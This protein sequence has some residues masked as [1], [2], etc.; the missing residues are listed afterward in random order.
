MKDIQSS[1]GG[2]T[3]P[4]E[5]ETT[6]IV[7]GVVVRNKGAY[8][9]RIGILTDDAS[10]TAGPKAHGSDYAYA[11]LA[12]ETLPEGYTAGVEVE[13]SP[14]RQYHKV[15][16]ILGFFPTRYIHI[17]G[18]LGRTD[19]V[20]YGEMS[21]QV[22]DF[23]ADAEKLG[24]VASTSE[25][26]LL[27][28]GLGNYFFSFSIH[29]KGKA[30]HFGFDGLKHPAR[31]TGDLN[32]Q[33]RKVLPG[34]AGYFEL[35]E[36]APAQT[37]NGEIRAQMRLN[38]YLSVKPEVGNLEI[39]AYRIPDYATTQ[40]LGDALLPSTPM[41]INNELVDHITVNAAGVTIAPS[42]GEYVTTYRDEVLPTATTLVENAIN[43]Y[44]PGNFQD[45]GDHF[46]WEPTIAQSEFRTYPA[47]PRF[48]VAVLEL[49]HPNEL[50]LVGLKLT[51]AKYKLLS[52][53]RKADFLPIRGVFTSD[54]FTRA[55]PSTIFTD[56]LN[57]KE[58]VLN[59]DSLTSELAYE[60]G[61]MNGQTATVLSKTGGV[62]R[63]HYVA[64]IA[65]P[66]D[67]NDVPYFRA[68]E[69]VTLSIKLDKVVYENHQ[70][71]APTALSYVWDDIYTT[72]N[73]V[74]AFPVINGVMNQSALLKSFEYQVGAQNRSS[75]PILVDGKINTQ[76]T[77]SYQDLITEFGYQNS[78]NIPGTLYSTITKETL[79]MG[80]ATPVNYQVDMSY[81]A[82]NISLTGFDLTGYVKANPA[83]NLN[84]ALVVTCTM[85]GGLTNA[86]LKHATS[87]AWEFKIDA[88]ATLVLKDSGGLPIQGELGTDVL[89]G[90]D[91]A[92]LEALADGEHTLAVKLT[93]TYPWLTEP[94]VVNASITFTISTYVDEVVTVETYFSLAPGGA[95]ITQVK[96]GVKVYLNINP[97]GS[98]ADG[99]T[100]TLE[101]PT[102]IGYTNEDDFLEVPPP[103]PANDNVA[104][105]IAL[106]GNS[107]SLTAT[108]LNAT[109][110]D[111]TD[112]GEGESSSSIWYKW[113][114]TVSGS[115]TISLAGSDFDTIM[116]LYNSAI[117]PATADS[118]RWIAGDDDSGGSGTSSITSDV[119]AGATY[120]IAVAGYGGREGNI[121]LTWSIS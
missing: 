100:Y 38:L 74:V 114:P 19:L 103:P 17:L 89:F 39:M 33:L 12:M 45:M 16:D 5:P 96:E 47:D 94:V 109:H 84:D 119:I 51:S 86:P 1:L 50:N 34:V 9:R 46:L 81:P 67:L 98:V 53:D 83:V 90:L 108:N 78:F 55:A 112:G 79:T 3:Y 63:K 37:Q 32:Y 116:G 92:D 49:N 2:S 54:T 66:T 4:A 41:H 23:A 29:N 22:A 59:A 106:T 91:K 21:N 65:P 44:H 102:G 36:E 7:K 113:T 111:L 77:V 101:Y 71:V 93:A 69:T 24:Q 13:L 82:T 6:G 57:D 31:L 40:A 104:D 30:Y 56:V 61:E 72:L 28:R 18:Q 42:N 80:F 68:G 99:T 14:A 20:G 11:P 110:E 107:G 43:F 52:G 64:V 58:F 97:G 117:E 8:G 85:S 73:D 48:R 62:Q 87:V 75:V 88:G 121:V 26:R 25:L 105:A 76:A 120:Y 70:L 60:F 95:P 10:I 35:V 15:L 118:L 115:A 27:D